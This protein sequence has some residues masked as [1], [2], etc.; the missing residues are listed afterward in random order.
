VPARNVAVNTDGGRSDLSM[1]ESIAL[2]LNLAVPPT[3]IA[4]LGVSRILDLV[5]QLSLRQGAV[6]M[7]IV[8]T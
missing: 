3:L 2:I 1:H 4:V 6:I 7:A 5:R 8:E